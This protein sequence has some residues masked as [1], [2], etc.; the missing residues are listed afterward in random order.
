LAHHDPDPPH[1]GFGHGVEGV[2]VPSVQ[3]DPAIPHI[4][5][6]DRVLNREQRHELVMLQDHGS[7][8]GLDH[9][10]NV[11]EAARELGMSRLRLGDH[12]RIPLLRQPP[13]VIGLGSRDIDRTLPC[14][15]LVIEVEHLVGESLKPALGD[16]DQPHGK[17]H[18]RQP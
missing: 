16:A 12:V 13:E 1:L 7:V 18:A 3:L 15:G 5:W 8:L 9:E 6:R 11:E 17:V 14:V 2:Q 4:V 10:P